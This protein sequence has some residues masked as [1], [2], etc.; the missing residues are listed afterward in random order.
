[1]APALPFALNI[2]LAQFAEPDIGALGLTI[3]QKKFAAHPL[4]AHSA[5]PICSE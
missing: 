5:F 2:H 4:N 3:C 1:M